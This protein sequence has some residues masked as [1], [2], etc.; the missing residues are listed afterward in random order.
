MIEYT[1]SLAKKSILIFGGAGF[2]GS[3][4][5]R[6]LALYDCKIH[7]V[8]NLSTGCFSNI[9]RHLKNSSVSFENGDVE[10]YQFSNY[11]IVFNLACPASPDQYQ[12]DPLKTFTTSVLGVMNICDCIK[13][14]DTILL[15]ASTSEV[16]GDPTVHPQN[17]NYWGNVNPIGVRSCYDEGKRAAETYLTDFAKI[18]KSRIIICRIFNTYGPN[19]N[20]EDGRVFSNFLHQAMEN[21]PLSIYGDGD[22]DVG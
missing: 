16:Y 6:H 18:H 4:L 7:I 1:G 19:L 11:D 20:K 17:E 12:K 8:D 10:T 3:N 14:T 5:V 9:E 21:R 22:C 2:I 15:H 13:N